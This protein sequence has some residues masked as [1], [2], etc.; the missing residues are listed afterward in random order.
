MKIHSGRISIPLPLLLLAIFLGSLV[1]VRAETWTVPAVRLHNIVIEGVA[2][3][4]AKRKVYLVT[5]T[6]SLKR[7]GLFVFDTDEK[8]QVIGFPRC[9]AMASARAKMNTMGHDLVVNTRDSKLYIALQDL[10]DP[11]FTTDLSMYNLDANGEPN[12]APVSF[13]SGA[14][15]HNTLQMVLHPKLGYLYCVGGSAKVHRVTL[16]DGVPTGETTELDVKGQASNI[17][18]RSD[19][20]LLYLGTM[21]TMES[22]NNLVEQLEVITLD[23]NGDQIEENRMFSA[24]D[25]R[26]KVPL[27]MTAASRGVYYINSRGNLAYWGLN[28]EGEPKG[29]EVNTTRPVQFIKA[30]PNGNLLLAEPVQHNDA[31]DST[32]TNILTGVAVREYVL[33]ATGAPGAVVNE[34]STQIETYDLVKPVALGADPSPVVAVVPQHVAVNRWKGLSV[35]FTL[36]SA[37]VVSKMDPDDIMPATDCSGTFS[38]GQYKSD[39]TIALTVG[40]PS[41][42]ISCDKGLANMSIRQLGSIILDPSIRNARV[43]FEFSMDGGKTI[44]KTFTVD[45]ANNTAAFF[46][47]GYAMSGPVAGNPAS[48]IFSGVEMFKKYLADIKK[49]V[50]VSPDKFIIIDYYWYPD[51]SSAVDVMA[52]IVKKSGHNCMIA[53]HS[54]PSATWDSLGV[55]KAAAAQGINKFHASIYNPPS[56]FDYDTELLTPTHQGKWADDIKKDVFNSM[57]AQPNEIALALIADEPGWYFPSVVNEVKD[58]AHPEHL[59]TFHAYLQKKGLEPSFFG[60]KTWETVKPAKLSEAKNQNK[61]R[62]WYW[63]ARF[64]SQSFANVCATVTQTFQ[65]RFHP[66][67]KTASTLNTIMDLWF[68][69]HPGAKYCN[70][71]DSGPDA[72]MAGPEWFD[73]GRSN[74]LTTFWTEDWFYDRDSQLWSLYSDL[75][76]CVTRNSTNSMSWGAHVA[77]PVTSEVPDGLSYK[78]LG[79]FGKGGKAV[80]TFCFGPTCVYEGGYSDMPVTVQPMVDSLNLIATMEPVLYPGVARNGT[81]A[82]LVPVDSQIWDTTYEHKLYHREMFGLHFALTHDN[83]PVDFVDEIDIENGKLAEYGYKTLYLTAPNLS[84]AAQNKVSAWVSKGGTCVMFPGAARADQYNDP[85]DIL[86]KQQGCTQG[87]VKRAEAVA[88]WHVNK[89][90]IIQVLPAHQSAL[91]AKSTWTR[92]QVA[93]LTVTSGAALATM[94]G[95][96]AIVQAASGSGRYLTYAWWPGHTYHYTADST[97]V[98]TMPEY[99]AE[100]R[101]FITAPAGPSF[102]NASRFAKS[103]VPMVETALL[104]SPGAGIAI[105]LSNWGEAPVK[106]TAISVN[107]RTMPPAI[108]A[109]VDQAIA[110]K[111]L[112]VQSYKS[113]AL[114]YQATGDEITLTLPVK[115]VDVVTL[116]W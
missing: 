54:D 86:Y 32:K 113:G 57:G 23:A 3:W 94:T 71:S 100:M 73:M 36:N 58:P 90:E 48:H 38:V 52:E 33:T 19:G 24:A 68:S 31:I 34:T 49:P 45:T 66:G 77:M 80:D 104:E 14:P 7:K 65:K 93:P 56:Y 83:F 87:P 111:A 47:P 17:G 103:S 114:T 42:W 44:P 64:F 67:V 51:G 116:T 18:I 53:Q 5:T 10:C 6:Y 72:C 102:G 16:K 63:T 106:S 75:M 39:T 25:A 4:A 95:G 30:M 84:V 55:R 101:A 76:R 43:K 89:E 78:M 108:L 15:N 74:A 91:G 61:R 69:P 107:K 29:E 46:A 98:A 41:D 115:T 27:A 70:N 109:A 50:N 112:K 12:G 28:A 81:V 22:T 9:Y 60:E 21:G 11:S 96:A 8:G 13:S 20:R 2:C 37:Q 26:P 79:L 97:N 99:D 40:T 35:R 62:L 105:S 85:T 82:I 1:G 92:M 110:K 88:D 59:A